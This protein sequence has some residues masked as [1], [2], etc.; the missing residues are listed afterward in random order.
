MVKE[1]NLLTMPCKVAT[2][3]FGFFPGEEIVYK[4]FE[5]GE[6]VASQVE[7]PLRTWLLP[8]ARMFLCFDMEK[9][10]M[11]SVENHVLPP[12]QEVILGKSRATRRNVW[13]QRDGSLAEFVL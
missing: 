10:V 13:R 5:D 12:A 3:L 1:H 2:A 9:P 11:V 6:E 7:L 4:V 8:R